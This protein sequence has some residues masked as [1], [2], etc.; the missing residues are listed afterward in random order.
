LPRSRRRR[1]RRRRRM[2]MRRLPSF[3]GRLLGRRR[4]EGVLIYM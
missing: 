4:E 2:E 3:G 1:R